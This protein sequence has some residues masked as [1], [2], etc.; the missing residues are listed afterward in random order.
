MEQKYSNELKTCVVYLICELG[1]STS[2]TAQEYNIPVKT[3]ENW[4]TKYN[5][6]KNT[7]NTAKLSDSERIAKLEKENQMLRQSNEVLKKTLIL[8]SKNV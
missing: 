6:N 7:F 1:K 2:K 5:K 8:L 4:V 3:V